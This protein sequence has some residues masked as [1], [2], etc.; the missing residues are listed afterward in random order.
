MSAISGSTLVIRLTSEV[1]RAQRSGSVH[2]AL[3]IALRPRGAATLALA[4]AEALMPWVVTEVMRAT[5]DECGRELVPLCG[6]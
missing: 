6:Q 5:A 1:K 3:W 2:A 4:L